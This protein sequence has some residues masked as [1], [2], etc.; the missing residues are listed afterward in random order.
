[1]AGECRIVC[2]EI[3]GK[4]RN[5]GSLGTHRFQR[6]FSLDPETHCLGTHRFQRAI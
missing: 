1:M 6:A 5:F 4:R 3:F 2:A